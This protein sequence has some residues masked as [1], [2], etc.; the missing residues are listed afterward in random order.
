MLLSWLDILIRSSRIQLRL[1]KI[2]SLGIHCRMALYPATLYYA[3]IRTHQG[4]QVPP[5]NK[6]RCAILIELYTLKRNKQAAS[7]QTIVIC[8]DLYRSVQI[9]PDL[10]AF[11]AQIIIVH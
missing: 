11:G 4:G 5:L 3:Q 9:C 1:S 10:R 2:Q 6:R 7:S 8:T